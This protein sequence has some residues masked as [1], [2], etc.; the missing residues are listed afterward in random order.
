M[1]VQGI[2]LYP[3]KYLFI[4]IDAIFLITRETLAR[5]G[6]TIPFQSNFNKWIQQYGGLFRYSSTLQ[7]ALE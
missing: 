4:Y 5:E 6:T 2:Q 7:G 3:Q 1:V